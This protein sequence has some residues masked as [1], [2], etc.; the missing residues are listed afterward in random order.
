MIQNVIEI[1]TDNKELSAY[2]GFL[3]IKEHDK[4]IKDIPFDTIHAF[5][6]LP[7]VWSIRT[8]YYKHCVSMEFL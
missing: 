3:R 8:I 6:S 5:L 7:E 1:S 4:V 2:R